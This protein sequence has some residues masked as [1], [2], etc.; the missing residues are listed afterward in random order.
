MFFITF[1]ADDLVDM[2]SNDNNKPMNSFKYI[3]TNYTTVA[4]RIHQC[5]TNFGPIVL[6]LDT[7]PEILIPS[8]NDCKILIL[9]INVLCIAC[10]LF[11]RNIL[12]P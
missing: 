12:P 1:K 9:R 8:S 2:P 4:G 11:E 6:V 5:F 10:S 3:F 7:N